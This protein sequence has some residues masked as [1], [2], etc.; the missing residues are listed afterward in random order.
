[1][2]NN[3]KSINIVGYGTFITKMAWSHDESTKVVRVK[4]F[5]RVMS[6]YVNT[7]PFVVPSKGNSFLALMFR[8]DEQGLK[9]LD[10]YEGI[11]FGDAENKES[12]RNLYYRK[13]IDVEDIDT[14]ESH[15]AWIYIPTDKIAEEEELSDKLCDL[16]LGMIREYG[17]KLHGAP[18]W[19]LDVYE[20]V[21]GK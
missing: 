9:E 21:Q 19:A 2:E 10:T 1:M 16:W 17:R 11:L 14:K 20:K 3:E 4:D 6:K 7:F 12:H 8:V 15:K 13:L 5:K 18:Q